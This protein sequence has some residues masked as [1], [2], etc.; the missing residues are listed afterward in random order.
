MVETYYKTN[1]N[2]YSFQILK[3]IDES[4]TQMFILDSRGRS[5]IEI[6]LNK[7]LSTPELLLR[8]ILYKE[9]CSFTSPFLRG[10]GTIAMIK[11]LLLF[12]M[13]EYKDYSYV[14]LKD[15]S[16]FDCIL[17]DELHKISIPLHTHNFLIYG[18][19][20]YQRI[21]G[22]FP[23][24][25]LLRIRIK[26][27][28]D[29]LHKHV[30]GKFSDFWTIKTDRLGKKWIDTIKPMIEDI[31]NKSLGKRSWQEFL[32][33][34][35]SKESELSVKFS[36]NIPC[37][38]FE[39]LLP[40]LENYFRVPT[41]Q[42]TDW[43]ISRETIETY[44]EKNIIFVENSNPSRK[45][46]KTDHTTDPRN[47]FLLEEI[48]KYTVVGSNTRK[49]S[50]YDK[51]PYIPKHYGGMYSYLLGDPHTRIYD[52]RTRKRKEKTRCKPD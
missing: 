22:A 11:A 38:I 9:S 29:H 42:G 18:E 13:K 12:A 20:W 17:P 21:F 6:M 8:D 34:L 41:F 24:T 51:I 7:N 43:K 50:R 48:A 10:E 52:T 45:K 4:I 26:E 28:L 14:V 44:P 5:C 16:A 23:E 31:F 2:G 46:Y 36:E 32:Y 40:H 3:T 30:E 39:L 33:L 37:S 47:L 1:F 15:G 25:D 19:T 49:R 35:F 27:S